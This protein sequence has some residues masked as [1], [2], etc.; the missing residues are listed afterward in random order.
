MIVQRI[1]YGLRAHT[2]FRRSAF[3]VLRGVRNPLGVKIGPNATKDDILGICEIL[4][5]SN[6][7]GRL[8]FIVRM[9]ASTILDRL[10]K[11]LE[12]IKSEG[13]EIVWSIDPMHGNTI[14]AS[15]GYK[16][17]SFDSILSEV[18]AFLKSTKVSALMQVACIW[19]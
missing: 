4:N 14:K 1:C 19:R 11:L 9:G 5:P 2:Q 16:T 10:P 12:S 17:R 7:A 18:K 15:S 6:E 13:K 8:N 3:G